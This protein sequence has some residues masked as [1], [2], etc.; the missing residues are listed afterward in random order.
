MRDC[1]LPISHDCFLR[2]YGLKLTR[3]VF[4]T[5]FVESA[6]MPFWGCGRAAWPASGVWFEGGLWENP[7]YINVCIAVS[8]T[9]GPPYTPHMGSPDLN[10]PAGQDLSQT[11]HGRSNGSQRLS[12]PS[13]APSGCAS[14]GPHAAG[15]LGQKG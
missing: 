2:D 12:F 4:P 13:S 10:G 7:S 11:L 6:C 8:N 3:G 15:L 9:L 14:L 1:C 5:S